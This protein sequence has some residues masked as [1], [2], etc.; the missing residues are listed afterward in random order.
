MSEPVSMAAELNGIVAQLQELASRVPTTEPA[1]YRAHIFKTEICERMRHFS[2]EQ[3]FWVDGLL[4]NPTPKSREAKQAYVMNSTAGCLQSVGAI[5]A[6]VGDRG[7]GKTTIAA[8]IALTR[9]WEDWRSR[10]S[11]GPVT[12]RITSYRK[13]T[14]IVGKLK[15]LYGDFGSIGIETLE[16]IRDH[17][18][19]VELLVI[20]ELNECSDD[21]KH[22][23]RILT[24]ILDRRYAA[25]RDSLLITNQTETEFRQTINPSILSRLNEHG[26]IIPCEWESFRG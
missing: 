18:A 23:D 5:V 4:A 7:L 13:L 20:D 6:L 11:G 24:D 9:I 21:S 12:H 3:R 26:A 2:F 16:A 17:L 19:S 14:A 8:Q 22:K 25:K 1:I 15:A 10:T